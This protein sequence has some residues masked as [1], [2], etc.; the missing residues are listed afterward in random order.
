MKR[1]TRQAD[2][3]QRLAVQ[4]CQ[5]RENKL[6]ASTRRSDVA[7]A[8]LLR[9]G[10]CIVLAALELGMQARAL[11][12]ALALAVDVAFV[13]V[14]VPAG[15][16]RMLILAA[17]MSANAIAQARSVARTQAGSARGA[18]A[19]TVDRFLGI[20]NA[21]APAGAALAR[22]APCAA[23][24]W[25]L[26]CRPSAGSRLPGTADNRFCRIS[27]RRQTCRLNCNARIQES[28]C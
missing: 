22:P 9:F 20:P 10:Q 1:G 2:R 12:L 16:G 19:R 23:V 27:E 21:K 28:T 24:R 4:L 14:D 3:A 17:A 5:A 11:S 15:V 26:R 13:G 6:D 7:V 8:S 25:S 18:T